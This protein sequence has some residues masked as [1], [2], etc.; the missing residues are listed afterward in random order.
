M[1]NPQEIQ[2]FISLLYFGPI[3]PAQ[4]QSLRYDPNSPEA[5]RCEWLAHGHEGYLD[6]P[7]NYFW[8][9]HSQNATLYGVC[10]ISENE[11]EISGYTFFYIITR[12]SIEKTGH[13]QVT[14]GR[15]LWAFIL[16]Y[17]YNTCVEMGKPPNFVVYNH[18]IV[19]AKGYHLK[20]GMKPFNEF[21][22]GTFITE[23]QA[24]TLHH[25][26]DDVPE[27]AGE[28]LKD[29]TRTNGDGGY[30]FYVSRPGVNYGSI[31]DIIASLYNPAGGRHMKRNKIRSK[32][33]KNN[34]KN[35]KTN[36]RKTRRN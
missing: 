7:E 17:C 29:I 11:D 12:C 27:P 18:T 25:I 16:N 20:M 15:L 2:Q 13:A 4:L 32:N 24:Y 36:K 21:A 22:P 23:Q 3:T 30:L 19:E 6:N 10:N 9:V 14:S 31:Y 26:E 1:S 35:K 34:K 28:Y 8:L 33:K 5:D